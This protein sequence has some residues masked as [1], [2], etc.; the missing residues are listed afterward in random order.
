MN[1]KL[2]K[3]TVLLVLGLLLASVHE[4]QAQQDSQY[5]QYMYNTMSMNPGYS[6]S[7][8]SLS[9]LAIYRDQWVGLDGSPRTLN[10]G[11]HTPIGIQGVGLGLGFTSDQIGPS[12]ESIVSA[13]FSYTIDF[14]NDTKLA[15]GIKGGYSLLDL[16]PNKLTIYDPNDYDLTQ[17]NFGS[18]I[19]GAGFYFYSDKW[20]LGLSTP[21]LLETEYY[22]DVQVSTATEKTHIYF[23]GGY[24]FTLN[25][26]LKLKP[27]FLAKAV[28][29]APFSFDISANA[30]LYDRVTFGLA[31][32]LD[33]A[34]SV[35]AGFQVSDN[36][37][38]GYA[39]DYETTAL[40]RY[41][42]GSHEIFLRFELGTRLRS[43]VNP[44]FF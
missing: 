26:N 12:T 14:E 3:L 16:D 5:T 23:I 21:N 29:G 28:V 19:V 24:V 36:V 18:P 25:S 41:N 42:S 39:Y 38:I 6:G 34:V 30:L 22:D 33:A 37:M 10:F 44:R 15:F 1:L 7:R 35:L 11:M 27:A 20:Y 4:T 40:S 9:I 31:Y 2:H 43:K 8:E 17:K 32:R 13:D